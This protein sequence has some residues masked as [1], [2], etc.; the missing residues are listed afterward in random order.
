[1]AAG[2]ALIFPA[3]VSLGLLTLILILQRL[4]SLVWAMVS[5]AA[6]SEDREGLVPVLLG[7][8]MTVLSLRFSR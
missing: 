7:F 3:I 6:D 4:L 2:R 5:P 1:M 8:T